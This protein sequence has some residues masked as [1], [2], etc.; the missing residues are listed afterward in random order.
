MCDMCGDNPV[1]RGSEEWLRR[2]AAYESRMQDMILEYGYAIQGVEGDPFFAYTVG[3]GIDG[4][5]D[6]YAS[7]NI[8]ATEMAQIINTVCR[9]VDEG[10]LDVE[11][12]VATGAD[13]MEVV[14]DDY[15]V[16][17]VPC[18][19]VAAGMT[20]ALKY[21]PDLVAYQILFPDPDGKF[22]GEEG[23]DERYS[24]RLCPA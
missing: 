24:Q 2:A 8:P 13:V 1:E 21:A 10:T 4:K 5:A 15:A 18:D 7:A 11:G 9:Y 17:F 22:P 20:L 23:Y 14:G 6:F 12:A 16:R 3:R 19:P